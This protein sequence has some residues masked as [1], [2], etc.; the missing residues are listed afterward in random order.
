MSDVKLS[1]LDG[2]N[3]PYAFV[4]DVVS[5]TDFYAFGSPMPNRHV[6]RS[7][8]GYRFGFNGQENDNDMYSALGTSLSADFWQYDSRLGRRWNIDPKGHESESPYATFGDNP[9]ANADPD[10]DIWHIVAGA[11]VGA[12]F[13]GLLEAGTQLYKHGSVTNWRAVGGA[14]VQGAVVGAVATATG[15]ATLALSTSTRVVAGGAAGAISNMLGGTANRVIQGQHTTRT[16]LVVDGLVGTGGAILGGVVGKTAQ[17]VIDKLSP[18]MKGAIGET[19]TRIKYA[20]QGYIDKGRA[21]VLTGTLTPKTKVQAAAHFDHKMKNVF[22]GRVLTVESKFNLGGYTPNQQL[23]RTKVAT[24][25]GLIESRT[26]SGQIASAA[27]G[28]IQGISGALERAASVVIDRFTGRKQQ[29]K[30]EF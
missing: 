12:V 21:K 7:A 29:P 2:N 20:A 26:T 22:T 30:M 8:A 14:M 24:Y 25:G 27:N 18:Q 23:A 6:P 13:G 17:K 16:N 1:T 10:G 28:A 9:I 5:R 19:V 4:A 11:G 15:G 3:E